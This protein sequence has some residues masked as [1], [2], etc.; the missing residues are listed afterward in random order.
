MGPRTLAAPASTPS[1]L[2][3]GVG[4]A[5]SLRHY[6]RL[7]PREA[8]SSFLATCVSND[9]HA[10]ARANVM[11]DCL[12]PKP[13]DLALPLTNRKGRHALRGQRPP[14]KRKATDFNDCEYTA[15]SES[16]GRR[17]VRQ[18]PPLQIHATS[19]GRNSKTG[20]S[21]SPLYLFL[22]PPPPGFLLIQRPAFPPFLPFINALTSLATTTSRTTSSSSCTAPLLLPPTAP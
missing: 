10:S 12:R 2:R 20:S 5:Q 9:A 16:S 1:L 19:A 15:R 7:G 17:S 14:K 11:L 4:A 22:P 18:C 6:H 13:Q 8:P 21:S 3:A